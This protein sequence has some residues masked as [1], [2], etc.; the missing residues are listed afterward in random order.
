MGKAINPFFTKADF[1]NYKKGMI[2]EL[3]HYQKYLKKGAKILD[4]GC[5]FGCMAIPLSTL[6][7]KVIGIDKDKQV[8]EAAQ[9]NAENFGKDIKIIEGDIFELDEIFDKDSFDVCISG[10]V[11]EHFK[12]GEIRKLVELQLKLAPV[13]I[14]SMPVKTERTMKA[15]GFTEETALNHVTLDGI[16]RNFWSETEWV[17]EVLDGFNVVEHFVEP[18]DP[19]IG[20][21]DLVYIIIKRKNQP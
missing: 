7:Y 17:N 19:T 20:E 5:G 9:K 6:G 1:E 8:V 15:Y 16:Y 10:G 14:A 2:E 18:C 12:K 11:L 21:F 13:V 3:K 4:L